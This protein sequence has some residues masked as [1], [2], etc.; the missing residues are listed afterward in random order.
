MVGVNGNS[1]FE[2]KNGCKKKIVLT[3]LMQKGHLKINNVKNL[4]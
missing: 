4:E 3:G 2:S 1:S